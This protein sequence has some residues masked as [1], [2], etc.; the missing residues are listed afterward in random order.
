M[1][2]SSD[3]A[4][5]T[6]T[7]RLICNPERGVQVEFPCQGLLSLPPGWGTFPPVTVELSP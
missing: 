2:L 5:P 7:A 4:W 1:L 6:W 3:V